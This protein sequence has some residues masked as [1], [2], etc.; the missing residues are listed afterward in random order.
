[1]K[2]KTKSLK[3]TDWV[4]QEVKMF[5]AKEGET[6]IR[7]TDAA[8]IMLMNS[9]GHKITLRPKSSTNKVK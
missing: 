5:A 3:V 9:R 2:A 4:Q 8:L 6:I 1:M 7:I